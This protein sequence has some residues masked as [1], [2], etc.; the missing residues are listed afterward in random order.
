M[1][2]QLRAHSDLS[3]IDGIVEAGDIAKLSSKNGFKACGI[4][5]INNTFGFVK[6]YKS[7][8]KVDVKP[9]IGCELVL[10]NDANE[11]YR[12]LVI[13]KHHAG[14][15]LLFGIITDLFTK[16]KQHGQEIYEVSI[17]EDVLLNKDCPL[18]NNA[19]IFNGGVFGDIYTFIKNNNYKDA[20]VK[21]S[22]WQFYY[23]GDY[24]FELQKFQTKAYLINEYNLSSYK[25][26]KEIGVKFIA[27]HPAL[28]NQES[29]FQAHQIK[30]LNIVKGHFDRTS[31]QNLNQEYTCDMSFLSAIELDKRFSEVLSEILI[32]EDEILD[33]VNIE[34]RLGVA[35]LPNFPI[36]KGETTETYFSKLSKDGLNQ[37]LI[38][39]FPDSVERENNR[40][41]YEDRLEYEL[42]TIISMKFP[43]YFLIVADFINWAKKNNVPVGPGR[44]SGAG[45]IVAYSLN[46][47]DL[48]PIP[49]DLLFERFLNPERV[50][51][52]DFDIDFCQEKREL[53][54]QYV[55][56]K[57]GRD[58]VSQIATFGTMASKSVIK[59]T[60]RV[61]GYP[62]GLSSS[63]ADRVQFGYDLEQTYNEDLELQKI[64][65]RDE[66]VKMIWDN[67]LKLEGLT[68]SIGKHAAGV[69]ISP[70][71]IS[72][73]CPVYQADSGGPVS[74]LDKVDVEDIGLVKF[75]FLGLKNLTII[76][77]A[78]QLVEKIS[79][80]KLKLDTQKFNDS[81]V[82]KLLQD[83]STTGVFQVESSGMKKYLMQMKPDCFEDI[84]AMLALYRPGP[85]GS[86]MVDDFIKRKLWEK[87]GKP[88]KSTLGFADKYQVS[89]YF[90]PSLEECLK[91]TYGIIVYQEQVMKISQ[92]IAGYSLGGADLLR[93]CIAWDSIINVQEFGNITIKELY[94]IVQRDKKIYTTFSFNEF[95]NRTEIDIIDDVF[96]SGLKEV[97]RI[98]TSSGKTLKLTSEHPLLTR[99]NGWM[100][101]GEISIENMI[102][103]P[104]STVD[105]LPILNVNSTSQNWEHLISIEKLGFEEVFDLT[106]RNNHNFIANGI[107]VHN[108]M[109]KKKPE[110]MAKQRETFESGA[111]KNGYDIDLAIH[112]FNLMEKFAEYGFN[113][114][115]SAAYAVVTYH[116]AYLKYHHSCCFMSATMSSDMGNLEHLEI[117]F[118]D[119]RD[120]GLKIENPDI[121][122]SNYRFNPI[123]TKTIRY[124]FGA[125]KGITELTAKAIVNERDKNGRFTSFV[126][127]FSRC[128]HH[129]DLKILTALISVGCFDAFYETGLKTRQNLLLNLPQLLVTK[130]QNNKLSIFDDLFSSEMSIESNV[131]LIDYMSN[132]YPMYVDV[133]KIIEYSYQTKFESKNPLLFND[134]KLLVK[135]GYDYS[136]KRHF[137]ICEKLK[138]K[139]ISLLSKTYINFTTEG[140]L[141]LESKTRLKYFAKYF[142][143]TIKNILLKEK[144]YTGFVLT[145]NLYD[146]Y[147]EYNK[148]CSKTFF[149]KNPKNKNEGVTNAYPPSHFYLQ[150]E[151]TLDSTKG[152]DGVI[153]VKGIIEKHYDVNGKQFLV[154][155]DG[156]K[157]IT[158]KLAK[159]QESLGSY[160]INR[161]FLTEG[162]FVFLK[163]KFN[164][165]EKTDSSPRKLYFNFQEVFGDV[166]NMH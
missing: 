75:D 129:L 41:L 33:K 74:Q 109:G 35:D 29:D 9:L 155:N 59:D 110:E 122:E 113:K 20:L 93:R 119:A 47:T 108:C 132:L 104:S 6:F 61:L 163:V 69:V 5:D 76:N 70:S 43:G 10:H 107:L 79:G 44:G 2:I 87:E 95:T 18:I 133:C 161:E 131:K 68:K 72:D 27:S 12:I 32:T 13:A 105:N 55:S 151:Q 124:A 22:L 21:A 141:D 121:N 152:I 117:L 138:K 96:F 91:P 139:T 11:K 114:S 94:D 4:N 125:I 106:I 36:P 116:T 58:S 118:N 78:V 8:K 14:L 145:A 150:N 166:I 164:F 160:K 82:Y 28:F 137:V 85:L 148:N 149:Y 128:Q 111:I 52:P 73:Y 146:A 63:I 100:K 165:N 143:E 127:F 38:E 57:Y 34:L 123:D 26:A 135:L 120:F 19:L 40:K 115:H 7:C 156:D 51:M 65:D 24:Y 112:L 31:L 3:I 90:T 83:G 15:N 130:Q 162:S 92:I 39:I 102:Y 17:P 136:T 157:S 71:K 153:L 23:K 126:N 48:N 142:P 144:E 49:Y 53:V 56:E 66:Q 30:H 134:Y 81:G 101:L 89:D 42:N 62:I 99:Y 159:T 80:E 50:S 97:F 64:I 67:A 77:E 86:G 98:V 60:A 154:I 37:R 158:V 103:I 88:D 147:I 84:V 16:Y 46:I 54:I 45:S 25:I 1:K 140:K